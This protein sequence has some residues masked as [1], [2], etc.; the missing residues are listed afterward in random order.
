MARTPT[1]ATFAQLNNGESTAVRVQGNVARVFRSISNLLEDPRLILD[2]RDA[3]V[4]VLQ[5]NG[6][7]VYSEV[8]PGGSAF[9]LLKS[10]TL[11][12]ISMLAD[13]TGSVALRLAANSGAAFID[14]TRNPAQPVNWRIIQGTANSNLLIQRAG[15]ASTSLLDIQAPVASSTG[16][17]VTNLDMGYVYAAAGKLYGNDV[18][19]T[20]LVDW[21]SGAAARASVTWPAPF[22][23]SI[24]AKTMTPQFQGTPGGQTSRC[25]IYKNGSLLWSGTN[26]TGNLQTE[27]ASKNTYTFNAGDDISF[28]FST[29]Y[30][31]IGYW[32]FHMLV[33]MDPR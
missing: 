11:N 27:T 31:A 17:R 25:D 24:L 2:P 5:P 6:A 26:N 13:T 22:A 16:L 10:S 3:A 28:R 33:E 9:F 8:V 19:A 29:S 14:F 18:P 23:G 12:Y 4:G 7:T 15:Q 1:L 32:R 20:P 21:V 30:S